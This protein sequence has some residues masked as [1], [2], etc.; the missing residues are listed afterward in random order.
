[1][2]GWLLLYGRCVLDQVFVLFCFLFVYST[3]QYNAVQY[4]TIPFWKHVWVE[5]SV[6]GW[7]ESFGRID[8]RSDIHPHPICVCPKDEGWKD[9]GEWVH[10]RMKK[11]RAH[12]WTVSG[13]FLF[14][15]FPRSPSE[16]RKHR[17]QTQGRRTNKVGATRLVYSL[18]YCNGTLWYGMVE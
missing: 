2:R 11:H 15:P 9:W 10:K 1:M 6:N 12:A 8:M 13:T 4:S 7:M 18:L 17:H 3:I 16:Q 14:V 5:W